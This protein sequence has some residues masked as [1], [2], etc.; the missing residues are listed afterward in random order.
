MFLIIIGADYQASIMAGHVY[1]SVRQ[2]LQERW[3]GRI[4]HKVQIDHPR[5][6]II[7]R[8]ERRKVD[9]PLYV[10]FYRIPYARPPIGP[11][12]FQVGKP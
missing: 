9:D 11:L 8:L 12:R 6:I 3:P 7:G 1:A 2:W 4:T 5:M 10:A